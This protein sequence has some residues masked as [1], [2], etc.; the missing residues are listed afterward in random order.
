[1]PLACGKCKG[2]SL[3][4]FI[5]PGVVSCCLLV[6]LYIIVSIMAELYLHVGHGKTGSSYIQSSLA[7]SQS[8][9]SEYGIDYPETGSLDNARR[10]K[11]TS[12]NGALLSSIEP[13]SYASESKVL[14]SS[15]VIFHDI[16]ERKLDRALERLQISSF[17]SINV[18][19]FIRDPVE[20]ASSSYQQMIKRGGATLTI[21]EAFSRYRQPELVAD[22]IEHCK[23]YPKI[24]LTIVNYSRCKSAVLQE[25]ESW[26]GIERGSLTSP[27]IKNINRSMTRSEL[28]F[29][30][31][32][33]AVL[34]KSGNLVS[35]ELCNTLP[36]IRPEAAL[37]GE[38]EQEAMLSRL[39]QACQYVDGFVAPEHRYQVGVVPVDKD[40]LNFNHYDFT[41][42]QVDVISKSLGKEI[43]KY[44]ERETYSNVAVLPEAEN[45]DYSPVLKTVK[46]RFNKDPADVLRDMALCFEN[47]GDIKTAHLLMSYALKARPGG[48]IIKGKMVSYTERIK[49]GDD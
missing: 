39:S 21:E 44:R 26:L 28:R 37:P 18:L 32:L 13:G 7:L 12:G 17:E 40:K 30:K 29:Q 45:D 33:N 47:G 49:R 9:L 42:E 15:E 5:F 1:M 35:D 22:F 16:V 27:A 41:G 38:K 36:D 20:H 43:K 2:F 6:Y 25:V 3:P 8:V 10:G 4:V 34:G 24:Q 48:K 46:A 11:I 19:L 31:A 23:K 14:L